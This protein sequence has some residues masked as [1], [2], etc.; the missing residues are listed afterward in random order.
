M[1]TALK[2]RKAFR[3][4]RDKSI[5]QL[6]SIFESNSL[7]VVL[8]Y[9]GLDTVAT[10]SLRRLLRDNGA[11]LKVVKNSIMKIASDGFA[12][13]KLVNSFKGS[14]VAVAFSC[15]RDPVNLTKVVCNFVDNESRLQVLGGIIETRVFD[16]EGILK[17]ASMSSMDQLYAELLST[18]ISPTRSLIN[19]LN[20]PM[21]HVVRMLKSYSEFVQKSN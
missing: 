17:I 20:S 6:K 12:S 11:I 13:D 1:S 14:S 16:F 15:Q 8:A 3:S 7:F 9:K 4:S 21:G 18:L 5:D 10:D 2:I 19:I